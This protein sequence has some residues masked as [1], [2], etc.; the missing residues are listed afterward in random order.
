MK[1]CQ[2]EIDYPAELLSPLFTNKGNPG[3]M[4]GICALEFLNRLN[5]V[6]RK[7]FTGVIAEQMRQAA[8]AWRKAPKAEN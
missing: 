5:C 1:C 7:K 3:P 8:I 6:N 4:C 2:C